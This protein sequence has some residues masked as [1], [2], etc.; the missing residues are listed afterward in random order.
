MSGAIISSIDETRVPVSASVQPFSQGMSPVQP[1]AGSAAKWQRLKKPF[2]NQ[3]QCQSN[4]CWAA[5]AASIADFYD[6]P[7][8]ARKQCLVAKKFLNLNNSIDCCGPSC[9]TL[10][11]DAPCNKE[12]KILAVL[13]KQKCTDQGTEFE[14]P[15][16][17]SVH[18]E[19]DASQPVCVRILWPEGKGHFVT[20][21][22]YLSH[23]DV[24][25]VEDPLEP[26][27]L[28]EISYDDLQVD[29]DEAGG[30]W[31]QTYF[32]KDV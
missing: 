16:L 17:S 11:E 15:K 18:D 19:I 14:I 28:I 27:D 7:M 24:L 5:V 22:G 30:T 12:R 25:L 9:K 8:A 6:K 3:E 4:W 21:T 1:F 32:T 31:D 26:D 29:Y 23:S 10:D 20:I 13:Y 2:K